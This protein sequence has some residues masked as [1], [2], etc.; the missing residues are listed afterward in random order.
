MDLAGLHI[1]IHVTYR[2]RDAD[3]KE[4]HIGFKPEINN[5]IS[6][7]KIK[8]Y[9]M[10]PST[11][12]SDENIHFSVIWDTG[13]T[14]SVS[15]YKDDFVGEISVP[16]VPLRLGG[17]A[18][19]LTVEGIGTVH[20]TFL[21][22]D[23]RLLHLHLKAYYVPLC[24]QRLL[25]P[26]RIFSKE[27]GISGCF[28]VLDDHAQLQ[29]A[30]KPV[31]S[32]D[33]DPINDLP[34]SRAI[35]SSTATLREE[36]LYLCVTEDRNQNLTEAQKE[37]LRWHYKLG[38][39]GPA[40]I[41]WLLRQPSFGNNLKIRAAARC[42]APKCA[43]CEYGKAHRK[44][45]KATIGT[46]SPEREG[47]VKLGD[48]YPGSGVSVDH[49]E[50]RVLGR[51]YSSRGKSHDS[52]MYKGGCIFVDHA[53]GLL[54]VHHQ[55][56]FSAT[57]TLTGK[58]Q[59]EN[60]AYNHGVLIGRY[61]TD[62]GT[63]GAKEFVDAIIA[64][65]Q[66]VKYC[67]VGAHHQNGAAERSIRTVSNM[68]RVMMLHASIRWPET[69][70]ATLW[71][72]AVDYAVHVYNHVPG[73]RTGQSPIDIFTGS[74]VPRHG[75]KDLHVWGCPCYVLDP[76]M[77]NGIKLPRWEPRSRR[78]LFVGMSPNHSSNVPLVLNLKTGNISPQF[79]V[80]FDDFFSTVMSMPEGDNPPADWETIFNESRFQAYFDEHDLP[81][82]QEEWLQDE[83]AY[84]DKKLRMEAKVLPTMG[85]HKDELPYAPQRESPVKV[86]MTPERETQL[87]PS[88]AALPPEVLQSVPARM[89]AV[90]TSKWLHRLPP[91]RNMVQDAVGMIP[92]ETA[93]V[94]QEQIEQPQQQE[95]SLPQR[96]STRTNR[97]P[98]RFIPGLRG[99]DG[100]LA[101][102]FLSSLS[103]QDYCLSQSESVL[104]YLSSLMT[105]PMTGYMECTNPIAFAAMAKR[106]D[107][108][109]P[110]YHEAMASI[111]SESFKEAMVVEI[112]A[113][114]AKDTWTI[115]PRA[116]IPN[117]NVLPGTWA[118][119]RKRFPDGRLRK[120][121]ARFCV[122]GDKQVEGVDYF[123]TYAPVVQWS[124]VRCLL[125]M[126][127]VL[128]LET[129]QIDYSNAFCQAEIEEE[130]Y[131]ELPKDFGDKQ[132][133]DMVLKLNKSL[134]GTK[135]A[136]RA[137]FLK[138]KE[139]LEERGFQQSKLDPCFFIHKDM[140]YLNYVD[141]GILIGKDGSKIESV[142]DDL[143][144]TLELTR[145]GDLSAFLGIQIDKNENG[146]L[147]L[148]Q[149]G[150]IKRVLEATK[151]QDCRPTKTPAIKETLGA[152]VNG[153]PAEEQWNYR[154]I[155]G[156]LLYLAS[157]SRPDIAFAVHQC[158]RFS[159]CPKVSHEGAIKKICR[160]LKGTATEGIVFTPSKEFAID[161]Y[162]DSDFA[163]LYGSEDSHDPV[164]A[165]SRTGYVITLAGCPL[166]WVSKLQTTIALSTMEAEYQALSAS[167][168][169]LI[170]L[171]QICKEASEALEITE[172]FI[173]RSHSKIYEDNSACLSQ[174]TMP[175][176]TPRT[177][178]IAVAYHWFRE[179][180]SS[181]D[182]EILKI[183]TTKQLGDIFTKG[184]V[185]E[186]FT[187]IRKLLCGW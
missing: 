69:A 168:R 99:Q 152:D 179:Y 173:V 46:P 124:T 1:D 5:F 12:F 80:V 115:I 8:P 23:G 117:K 11:M 126:S 97:A 118:F 50:S 93:G 184:L 35:R 145:E 107:P 147:K 187:A 38:H 109:S 14:R 48:I 70:D 79:H 134:Y 170:P 94:G 34:T 68:A 104:A 141:D 86:I 28:V 40:T 127:I 10:D 39:L 30:G 153:E 114:M 146:S 44:P 154:S 4:L 42:T 51:Q 143:G 9:E 128:G 25:S 62:N 119:K 56:G 77:Q 63:F 83:E 7:D 135:Q 49:F 66:Q 140:V 36:S 177:K 33:Y 132:G 133:R 103:E 144:T 19:G 121:K 180:V 32:I 18:S 159:H 183:E 167:C 57:E 58:Q 87:S 164:C 106:S 163:G 172:R 158:A 142:I 137:W 157:N 123:E 105:D 27:Q 88:V 122:R 92:Q 181:G 102:T 47:K 171:R 161:C 20:W 26:Q 155:V 85:L 139:S 6:N 31:L 74:L 95:M 71:P 162:V 150:L 43:A 148:T 169:D 125:V 52:C 65:G 131:V 110:R 90:D 89:D 78:A 116:S 130:V 22:D 41:Q 13:A 2:R 108:D 111:D 182:I 136:P 96:R 45:L 178:H 112:N 64:R 72:M 24:P 3:V 100:Y 53:S 81:S 76:K 59:F 73:A 84:L 176:M 101:H 16:K 61:M 174:A 156:M 151:M 138:L 91:T 60:W 98:Q 186:K 37:Y 175:K 15:G 165:K 160:Y 113:L 55:V 185:A 17:I 82:L 149:E 21:S 67:G 29:I 75:L 54:Y 120:C 129:R 166:L